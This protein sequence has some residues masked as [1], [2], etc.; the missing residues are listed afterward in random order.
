MPSYYLNQCWL[1]VNWTIINKLQWNFRWNSHFFIGKNAFENAAAK[2][3]PFCLGLNVLKSSEVLQGIFGD[4]IFCTDKNAQSSW[5]VNQSQTE[6]MTSYFEHCLKAGSALRDFS[7]RSHHCGWISANKMECR[8]INAWVNSLAP[9]RSGSHF[10]STI[11]KLIIQISNSH[12]HLMWTSSW[13]ECRWTP[14]III[15][16]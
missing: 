4:C 12:R 7:V 2:R 14:L 13:G 10:E 8:C 6:G 11:F 15:Q 3:Q 1:I 9:G 16:H 5:S